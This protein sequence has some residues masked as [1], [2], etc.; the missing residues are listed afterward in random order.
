MWVTC[1]ICNGT[2]FK[3][4]KT[5]YNY[6]FINIIH[7]T[8]GFD[9]FECKDVCDLCNNDSIVI[10]DNLMIGYIFVDDHYDPVSPPSSPRLN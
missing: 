4:T 10:L 5:K 2:G 9:T 7:D 3:N 6:K 1:H 8:D